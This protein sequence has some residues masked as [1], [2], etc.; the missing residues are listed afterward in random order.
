[1]SLKKLDEKRYS[2]PTRL[3]YGKSMTREWD[4]SH[5]VIPPITTSSTFR[6]DSTERGAQ[7]FESIGQ[8]GDGH[9]P[10]IYIYDRMGEPTVDMLQYALATA[11][12]K[13]V[14]VAFATGMAAVHAAVC[15]ALNPG[16]EIISHKTIY[17][18]TYSLFTNWL[19]KLGIK[20][21]FCDLTEPDSFLPHVNEN[22][23]VLFLESP[24]NPNLDLLDTE[25]IVKALKPIN[26]KRNAEQQILTVM[27][28][29]FATPFCQRPGKQGIDVVVH[30]L[31]K[32]LSGF[33][34]VM[35]GAVI[36]QREFQLP[37]TL[38]RKDFGGMLAPLTA[39]HILVYGVS[40]LSLRVPR[41]QQSALRI[42]QFLEGHPLIE[43][44]RYPGLPSF[45]QH[46]LA[47]RLMR[48]YE[49]NFAPGF[50]IYFTLKGAAAEQSKSRG[51]AM[52]NYVAQNA[53]SVTLAVSLGQLRTL[54][55][56][57]GSMTHASYPG[58]E[59]IARGIDPGGIR[60]AVGIEN[61][62]DIIAD[63]KTAL[64]SIS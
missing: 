62:D 49:G 44:V 56:H 46:E 22:T 14:A 51:Q 60:L 18:C 2:I 19:P 24:V 54:I 45:P 5:H 28:N 52:M 20:V 1:M 7:G 41:Q 15:F 23:R 11:E 40:T 21:H 29:T 4:Y 25:A 34:T 64:E 16:S 17:G 58:E 26:D 53:Y 63:L 3:I 42:A 47:K 48:D 8:H 13:E 61:P 59:Q 37:L 55:E 33:G 9:T 27:D 39:W 12:E 43:K 38:F 57:P 36:T 30:S 32:G 50:I 31:T 10:P 35:G 6:L